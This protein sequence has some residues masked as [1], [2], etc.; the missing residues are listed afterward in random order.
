MQFTGLISDIRVTLGKNAV[1]FGKYFDSLLGVEDKPQSAGRI[2]EWQIA[3][4]PA[5]ISVRRGPHGKEAA[6]SG[7]VGEEALSNRGFQHP[8]VGHLRPCDLKPP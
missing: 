3:T 1:C 2:C 4:L 5:R 6:G 7:P 8:A